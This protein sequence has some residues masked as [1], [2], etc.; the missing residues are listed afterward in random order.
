VSMTA[1]RARRID[2]RFIG[3]LSSFASRRLHGFGG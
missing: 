3:S 1:R 2:R